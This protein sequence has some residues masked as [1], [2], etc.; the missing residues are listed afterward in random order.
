MLFR[1]ITSCPV[2]PQSKHVTVVMEMGGSICCML[3]EWMIRDL[4]TFG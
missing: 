4:G 3:E 2:N 1:I